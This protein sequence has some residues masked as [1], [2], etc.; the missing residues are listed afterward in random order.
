MGTEDREEL[1]V[2]GRRLSRNQP[3]RATKRP[4]TIK[5]EATLLIGSSQV[6]SPFPE[7]IRHE[8]V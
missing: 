5:M 4:M 3:A 2:I 6:G 8:L 7:E 1:E